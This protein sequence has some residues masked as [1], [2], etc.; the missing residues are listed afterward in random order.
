MAPDGYDDI[1]LTGRHDADDENYDDFYFDFDSELDF[2][3][4]CPVESSSSSGD[5]PAQDSRPTAT[6]QRKRIRNRRRI[7]APRILKRDYR[8]QYA[9]MMANIFNSYDTAAYAAFLTTFAAPNMRVRKAGAVDLPASREFQESFRPKTVENDLDSGGIDWS[10]M[11][12]SVMKSL[13]PDMTMRLESA[14]LRT[15]SDTS[16][17]LL[18]V[19]ARIAYTRLHDVSSLLVTEDMFEPMRVTTEPT[20]TT[21]AMTSPK[22][23]TPPSAR[24]ALR[25]SATRADPHAYFQKKIGNAMPMLQE[26]QEVS[27]I[28]TVNFYF[29]EL[30]RMEMFEIVHVE[31]G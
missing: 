7:Y 1:F 16:K 12:F 5:D 22:N 3:G 4:D 14:V 2:I 10:V 15:R 26:P 28:G 9:T 20:K 13:F 11:H 18:T 25:D 30:R 23:T 21:T 19:K 24:A 6:T 29:D 17:T 31:F 8:R 27:F